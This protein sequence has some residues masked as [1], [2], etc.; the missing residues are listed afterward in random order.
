MADNYELSKVN[1]LR[2][3]KIKKLLKM[4]FGYDNFRMKQYEIINKII[5]Y[6]IASIGVDRC[7][8][9]NIYSTSHSASSCIGSSCCLIKT[10]ARYG[11]V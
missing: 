4:V 8:I 1:T 11:I 3:K 10:I 7:C 9:R 2:Y 5:C 6:Y